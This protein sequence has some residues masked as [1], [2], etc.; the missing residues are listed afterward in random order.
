MWHNFNSPVL[1]LFVLPTL[2]IADP[3]HLRA[4]MSSECHSSTFCGKEAEQFWS[5]Y[6]QEH[7]YA[8]HLPWF[9]SSRHNLITS[10]L[11]GQ[12]SDPKVNQ[13]LRTWLNAFIKEKKIRSVV[14]SGCGHWPTSWQLFVDWPQNVRIFAVDLDAAMIQSTN[15][16]IE[17]AKRNLTQRSYFC[18]H[19]NLWKELLHDKNATLDF[20]VGDVTD[21]EVFPK[22]E[23]F[24]MVMTFDTLNILPERALVKKWLYNV[25]QPPLTF[26][27][28]I[29][30]GTS[31]YDP[32]VLNH[33]HIGCN[34]EPH[35]RNFGPV[36]L[37]KEPYSGYVEELLLK[38]GKVNRQKAQEL[39]TAGR[40]P[41]F[42]TVLEM[43]S[44]NR[45]NFADKDVQLLDLSEVYNDVVEINAPTP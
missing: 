11:W 35:N 26:K 22:N 30:I 6:E 9:K 25:L 37:S 20:R 16:R 12:E 10:A 2:S 45:R 4:R 13:R 29:S 18:Q 33:K 14:D 8:H 39:R 15:G 41:K 40:F 19:C 38:S 7:N 43:K 17:D 44:L 32:S 36:D 23:N 27:Y 31:C 24:D 42:K 28:I 34:L 3:A 21:P 5:V 1:R